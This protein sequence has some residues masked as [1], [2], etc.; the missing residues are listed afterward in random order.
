MLSPIREGCKA[1][2]FRAAA[3]RTWQMKLDNAILCIHADRQRF[4]DGNYRLEVMCC[5][6]DYLSDPDASLK[7]WQFPIICHLSTEEHTPC[8]LSW[9]NKNFLDSAE[10]I[11]T[12]ERRDLILELFRLEVDPI[13]E[14][15]GSKENLRSFVQAGYDRNCLIL[16]GPAQE[17]TGGNWEGPWPSAET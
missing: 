1:R 6:L 9:A 14:R 2:G 4:S 5:F 11:A 10:P 13:L 3:A 12:E 17:F 8:P 7:Y 16:G 15:I